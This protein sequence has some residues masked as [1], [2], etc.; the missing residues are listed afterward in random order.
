MADGRSRG[1]RWDR[2]AAISVAVGLIAVAPANARPPHATGSPFLAP[3]GVLPSCSL[4]LTGLIGGLF[5]GDEDEDLRPVLPTIEEVNQVLGGGWI[6]P[7]EDELAEFD[8]EEEWREVQ[9]DPRTSLLAIRTALQL[10]SDEDFAAVVGSMEDTAD[11]AEQ[12]EEGLGQVATAL[13]LT[14]FA[15]QIGEANPT[16]EEFIGALDEMYCGTVA[17]F[18]NEYMRTQTVPGAQTNEYGGTDVDVDILSIDV[19]LYAPGTAERLAAAHPSR[20]QVADLVTAEQDKQARFGEGRRV[21]GLP[22]AQEE[23][24]RLLARDTSNFDADELREHEGWVEYYEEE[25]EDITSSQPAAGG[26][27]LSGI[28]DG[29]MYWT[30]SKSSVRN[31][32]MVVAHLQRGLGVLKISRSGSG[33]YADGSVDQVVRLVQMLVERMERFER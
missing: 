7:W 19:T 20:A 8:T 17:W 10:V 28:A 26:K 32:M 1:L 33:P 6:W 27:Y 9:S 30:G 25:V 11:R 13:G 14:A 2:V 23:L 18:G 29:W 31:D 22:R 15:R 12:D 24:A 3:Q 5:A 21:E 4:S 16:K